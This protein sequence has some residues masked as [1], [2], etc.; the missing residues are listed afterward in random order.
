MR[1]HLLAACMILFLNGYFIYLTDNGTA[2]NWHWALFFLSALMLG[3]AIYV[4]LVFSIAFH[5]AIS[6]A[7]EATGKAIGRIVQKRRLIVERTFSSK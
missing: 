1:R 6:R 5:L 4:G 3:T 7:T 2:A